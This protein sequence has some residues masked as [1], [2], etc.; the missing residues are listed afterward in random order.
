MVVIIVAMAVIAGVAISMPM[1]AP[2]KP[3]IIGTTDKIT[4]MDPAKSY[5]FYTWEVFNN[6]GEGLLRYKSGTTEIVPG[7]AE[8]YEVSPD[9]REYTFKLREG[10]KFSDGTPFDASV[11]KWSVDRVMRL[12]LDPAWL[13]TEFVDRVEV[14]DTHTVKFVLKEPV[15]FFPALVAMDPP[16]Y[17]ISPKA[18][19]EDEVGESTVSIGPYK[20]T[21]W[22]RDVELV[23]EANPDYWGTPPKAKNLVIKFFKDAPTMRMALE[24][25]EIDVAWRT[26]PPADIEDLRGKPELSVVDAPGPYIRYIIVRCDRPPFDDKRLRQAVA[27]AVDRKAI[28]DKVFLGTVAPLYSMVPMGMWSHIDGFLDRY[29]ERD[30]ELSKRLL[31]DAGYS[32]ANPFEFDLWYTPTHYGDTEKDVAAVIKESLEGTGM[33]KVTLKSA[34]WATFAAEY[35]AAG[36]MPIFLLGWYPDYIDPDNYVASFVAT[37]PE[38]YGLGTFYYNPDLLDKMRTARSEVDLGKRTELYKEIQTTF[39]EEVAQI[40][41]FQG[42]LTAVTQKGVKG[43]IINPYLLL[44]YFL[45][46]KE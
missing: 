4:V 14:V 32:E 8:S 26:L 24:A 3:L 29:G 7:L 2:P 11:V 19:P 5:D 10:L 15:G 31:A 28:A 35:I 46:Y 33:M 41:L 36:T 43:I 27:A 20:V 13:V 1:V 12:D 9:G 25:G 17:P 6:I 34:E 42:K 18:W 38:D 40:P 30:V 37:D 23:M 22:T 44:D 16:Y 45:I 39:A 21:K